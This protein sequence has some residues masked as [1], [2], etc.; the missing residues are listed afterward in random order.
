MGW[1]S[2]VTR[3]FRHCPARVVAHSTRQS[4]PPGSESEGFNDESKIKPRCNFPFSTLQSAVGSQA[5]DLAGE[6]GD[7]AGMGASA[8]Q[9]LPVGQKQEELAIPSRPALLRGGRGARAAAL[10]MVTRL[11]ARWGD[12]RSFR[13]TSVSRSAVAVGNRRRVLLRRSPQCDPLGIAR[14]AAHWGAVW[15]GPPAS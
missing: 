2:S 11:E 14:R 8:V 9:Q 7:W 4:A 3:L 15:P 10:L 6:R 13:S 12:G 1:R 5:G